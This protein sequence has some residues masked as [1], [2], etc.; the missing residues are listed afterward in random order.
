MLGRFKIAVYWNSWVFS[1]SDF[2][3]HI[4]KFLEVLRVWY[5]V[6]GVTYD[7]W[8]GAIFPRDYWR[9]F[10]DSG[11][12]R[13]WLIIEIQISVNSM[14][15]NFPCKPFDFSSSFSAFMF[16]NR[17]KSCEYFYLEKFTTMNRKFS[18]RISY[19]WT[20]RKRKTLFI[21]M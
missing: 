9:C 14:Y 15:D 11:H 20:R 5:E 13:K 18:S 2:S 3:D 10:D 6:C 4:D 19:F 16:R 8:A 7:Q 1:M 12:C 21:E 17:K